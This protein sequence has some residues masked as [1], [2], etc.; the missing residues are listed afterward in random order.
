MVLDL[1]VI[2]PVTVM[3]FCILAGILY[4]FYILLLQGARARLGSWSLLTWS[5]LAGAP[6]LL[7]IGRASCRER[8]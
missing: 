8:V 5:S 3:L 2:A 6:V 7:E 1:G 4:A